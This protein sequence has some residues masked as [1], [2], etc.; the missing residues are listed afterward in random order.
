MI[1][2]VAVL[3]I[4][5]LAGVSIASAAELPLQ[6]KPSAAVTQDV[7]LVG[8]LWDNAGAKATQPVARAPQPGKRVTLDSRWL[9]NLAASNGL[10][11]R[12]A[13]AF[14]R[15]VV[16]R[17][18]Q[19]IDVSLVESELH[20]ALAME[21]LPATSSFEISGRQ[22]L[23][24]IVPSDA[25]AKVAIREL[26]MDTHNQRFAATVEAPAGQPNAQRVKIMG[27]I[28]STTRLPMLVR[29]MNRGE[30][31]TAQDLVWS[32]VRDDNLRQDLVTDPKQ[33]I[34]MEPR[35]LLRANAPVRL[36]ELQ[37]PM[38]ITRNG[39]VT[40]QLQTP[41]MSLS[42]QGRAME[43]AGIGDTVRV[44][45]LQTKQVVEARVQ[46]PGLVVVNAVLNPI[47]ARK[48]T[49]QVN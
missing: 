40:M 21:G 22:T 23:S 12:P 4:A 13:S 34:G 8:D 41:Y 33:L 36:A 26:V 20:D 48:Q 30:V 19:T 47:P 43:D 31:I 10:D 24:I 45:N 42:T 7:I 44:T 49:A 28:F 35:Q 32:D 17:S 18:G 25:P 3:L 27:R 16:E 15:I 29:V 46:G 38:A 6:L 5:V 9:G 39:L 1:R 37:R 2:T 14:D 11:W